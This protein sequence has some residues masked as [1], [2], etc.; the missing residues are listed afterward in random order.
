MLRQLLKERFHVKLTETNQMT[1][2]YALV[3]AK[4]GAHVKEVPAPVAVTGDPDDALAKWMSDHPGQVY[5]GMI[6]CQ[7]SECSGHTV[8]MSD[9]IGQIGA[10]AHVD[11]RVIDETGL[12]GFYDLSFP[13]AS[14]EDPFPMQTVADSLGVRFVSKSIPMKTYVILSATKPDLDGA[15]AQ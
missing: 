9:A 5:Q 3:Q 12:T 1:P 10:C 2:V 8:K 6:R 14:G 7:A 11:R 15:A 4:G 13:Y